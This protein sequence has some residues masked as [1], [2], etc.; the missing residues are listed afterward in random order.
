MGKLGTLFLVTLLVSASVGMGYGI[1]R[2][3]ASLSAATHHEQQGTVTQVT[4]LPDYVQTAESNV[5][6]A[7]Q[8]ARDNSDLLAQ[9]PCYCGCEKTLHHKH[10][11]DCYI[12]AFHPD[13][14]VA[15]YTDHAAYCGVCVDTTLLARKLAGEG[16][17]AQAIHTAIDMQYGY[18]APHTHP[19]ELVQ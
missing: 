6:V 3:S 19:T 9:M 12:A 11:L 4:H 18:T 15:Q 2:Q 13:G 16:Q 7:Y 14:S 5:Q 8:F 10:N 1:W 17:T